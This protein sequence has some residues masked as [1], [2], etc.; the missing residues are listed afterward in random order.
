MGAHF[1]IDVGCTI[2]VDRYEHLLFGCLPGWPY[3]FSPLLLWSWGSLCL[4]VLSLRHGRHSRIFSV[5]NILSLGLCTWSRCHHGL[6]AGDS[7]DDKGGGGFSPSCCWFCDVV[8]LELSTLLLGWVLLWRSDP[9]P[10]ELWSLLRLL[11]RLDFSLVEF[12]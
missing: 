9:C 11:L 7:L 12:F 1:D 4:G 8:H 5:A 3:P 6:V 10:A 2:A